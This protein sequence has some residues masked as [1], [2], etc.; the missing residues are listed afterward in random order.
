MPIENLVSAAKLPAAASD[1]PS[2]QRGTTVDFWFDPACPWAWL[3]SRW[4][5]EVASVRPVE[6][7]FR[8]MSLAVLNDAKDLT[9]E[10]REFM[11][12]GWQAT[13]LFAAIARD[14]GQEAVADAYTA[15]GNRRHG[16][17]EE[18]DHDFFVNVIADAGLPAALIDRIDD[19]S[20]ETLVRESHDA[21]MG[22]VGDEV[23]TPI[24]SFNGYATFGPIVSRVPN[25]EQAGVLW[26]ALEMMSTVPFLFEIKKTRTEDP[27]TRL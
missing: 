25:A 9:P 4:I 19:A 18:V 1:A 7:Y 23:G 26:D 27:Q 8:I 5:L 10:Y 24:I 14:H 17:R 2:E 12:R 11:Q 13:R 22:L 21:G 20:L 6:P 3:T 16:H 15:Y